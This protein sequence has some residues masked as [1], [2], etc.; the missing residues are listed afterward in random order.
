MRK[1][2][3]FRPD[4]LDLFA[5]EYPVNSRY[6]PAADTGDRISS[7]F[8]GPAFDIVSRA[9]H[10]ARKTQPGSSRELFG[11]AEFFFALD[12]V[13]ALT[14]LSK[15]IDEESSLEAV[16]EDHLLLGMLGD[17]YRTTIRG[18]DPKCWAGLER[19]IEE[20]EAKC[21]E[22]EG[23]FGEKGGS[24]ESTLH[25]EAFIANWR[26]TSLSLG[27]GSLR[28]SSSRDLSRILFRAAPMLELVTDPGGLEDYIEREF[29]EGAGNNQQRSPRGLAVR[30]L[31][32]FVE[33]SLQ[34]LNEGLRL[35]SEKKLRLLP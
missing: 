23:C 14:L 2:D 5:S 19:T 25:C 3:V 32:L 31:T 16:E 1:T 18:A 8:S 28:S 10:T 6:F 13:D 12:N 7:F 24:A 4:A 21:V 33:Y 11:G 22:F 20:G 35:P 27:N 15:F 29:C 34:K 17:V 9:A 26:K 30:L